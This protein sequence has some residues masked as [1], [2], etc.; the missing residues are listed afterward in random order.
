MAVGGNTV[1]RAR[2]WSR[3]RT[4]S[5]AAG[6]GGA[7]ALLAAC[8]GESTKNEGSTGATSGGAAATATSAAAEQPKP[9][10]IISQR[11]Q[12]DPPSMDIHQ[13]TTY[14]GVWPIAPCFNQLVQFD[15][16]KVSNTEK[17]IVADLAEKWETPDPQT[18]VFTLR[19]G[20]TFHDGSAFTSEDVKVQ[21][22]WIR[23]PPQGKTSPRAAALTTIDTIETPDPTTVR[24][25]LTRPTP[26]LILNLASH[27][28]AI[29]QAK[30]IAANG[31]VSNKLIGTGPFKLKSYQRGNV[32]E[33]EKNPA[34]HLQGRPYLD[35]LKFFIIADYNSAFTNFLGGQYQL[36]YDLGFKVSDQDR[37][38][39]ELGDKVETAL[40]PS[41]LRDIVF[42][43]A[44]HKP[45]D[46][47]RVRQAINLALDRDAA[48]KVLKEGAG[49]RGGYMA[50]KGVW[51]ISDADL[52]KYDGYDKPNIDKAKQLLQQAGVPGPLD[53]STT[54][55]TDFKDMGEFV[56]DQLGKIGI[57]VKLTLG[58]TATSQP[59]LQ[60]GDFDIGPWAVAINVDDPDAT[61]SEIATSN[62]VRNWSAVK[63]PQIDAL[64]DKQSQTVNAD[65]RKKIV[66]E[67]EKQ[68]LSQ[69]QI[70]TL[71]FEDLS[72]A[73]Y[74]SVRSFVV[75]ESLYTNRRME[76]VWLQQ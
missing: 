52:R 72:F 76:A 75:Q 4:L 43:N 24:L 51:A 69:Y 22:D 44:R 74:K 37:A 34:Y 55:R 60:R 59:V 16:N 5:L 20:V 17:D 33:L 19:K 1:W 10:G 18:L 67:L 9:G 65:E 27:Y 54:T 30:D 31:E 8:G 66:Q 73:K 70:A 39:Q 61:F 57:N 23:K 7:A 46:D 21:L 41:T 49:R 63:D 64:F 62:A 40:V 36:F 14:S 28:F 56:K 48:I 15:P 3:R 6:G 71:L 2:R 45:Y 47:I 25:R 26:S 58:D 35:G 68:A 53:A 11:L 13:V 42:M 50:P 12:T 29:G 38:K 32:L